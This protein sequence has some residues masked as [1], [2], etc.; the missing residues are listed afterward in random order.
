MQNSHAKKRQV[1]GCVMFIDPIL[2]SL[3][4]THDKFN[5]KC[6]TSSRLPPLEV[7]GSPIYICDWVSTS[8]LL[9]IYFRMANKH[10][11]FI[12]LWYVLMMCGPF[13]PRDVY[14][15]GIS[16]AFHAP[17]LSTCHFLM[18][19]PWPACD[20]TLMMIPIIC[21]M[22]AAS[23]WCANVETSSLTAP[24]WCFFVFFL[25]SPWSPEP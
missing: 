12:L 25:L 8:K 16:R 14:L 11:Q 24:R 21:P 22:V 6:Q 2:G 5:Q 18:V 9:T 15:P 10:G 19:P 3:I 7:Q 20:R 17:N 23:K 1:V 13:S 4:L